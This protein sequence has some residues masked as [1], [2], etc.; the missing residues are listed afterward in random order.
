LNQPD[1]ASIREKPPSI[2]RRKPVDFN[3]SKMS[4][5]IQHKTMSEILAKACS[6][7]FIAGF[8]YAMISSW[9][10]RYMIDPAKVQGKEVQIFR[11][12]LPPREVLTD[13]GIKVWWSKWISLGLSIVFLALSVFLHEQLRKE[14]N[15][16][17]SQTSTSSSGG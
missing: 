11:S 13:G 6:I 14:S 9:I 8:T 7:L 16:P 2:Q 1:Q 10:M 4:W 12:V 5:L 3:K 15:S 17:R